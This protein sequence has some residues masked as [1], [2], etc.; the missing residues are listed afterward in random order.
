M[1]LE[2]EHPDMLTSMANLALTFWN[3]GRW[4]EAEELFVQ[5]MELR[6]RV[7]GTQHPDN[8]L[9]IFSVSSNESC[10]C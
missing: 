5:V 2:R 6:K 1:A 4:Q 7:L 8:L 9:D 10:V 3:Q